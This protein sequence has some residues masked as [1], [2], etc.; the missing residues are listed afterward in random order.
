M[1]KLLQDMNQA[2]AQKELYAKWLK[3]GVITWFEYFELCKTGSLDKLAK[4][5]SVKKETA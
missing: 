3:A 2:Y 1:D 4:E 5:T